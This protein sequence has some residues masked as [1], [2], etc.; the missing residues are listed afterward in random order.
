MI[1]NSLFHYIAKLTAR[2]SK[3]SIICA[4][5][6]WIALGCYTGFQKLEWCSNHHDSFTTIGDPNWGHCLTALP[7]IAHNFSFAT[8]SNDLSSSPDCIT[9]TT[10][11]F[12]KQKNNDNGQTLMHCH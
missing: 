5:V 6:N 12:C 2:T 3:D 1:S 9:F 8:E 10:L 11:C 7:I 4:I